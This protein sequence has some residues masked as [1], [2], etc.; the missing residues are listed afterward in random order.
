MR[1]RMGGGNDQDLRVPLY[2]LRVEGTQT[3]DHGQ[4][5]MV[6][7]VLKIERGKDMTYDAFCLLHP[8]SEYVRKDDPELE[9]VLTFDGDLR[10]QW[11]GIFEDRRHRAW[12][13]AEGRWPE[14]ETPLSRL[15]ATAPYRHG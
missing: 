3:T 4:L 5:A 14:E 9:R 6:P 12:E 11:M 2:R 8:L 7:A 10:I 1:P 13:I 15:L